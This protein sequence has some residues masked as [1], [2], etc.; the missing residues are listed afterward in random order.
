[1]K[2]LVIQSS[3][4]DPIGILGDHLVALGAELFTWLPEEQVAPPD[5]DFVGL[6]ILGGHMNA[7]EDDKFPHLKKLLTSCISFMQTTNPLWGFVWGLSS[8]PAP[9]GPRSIP[10]APPS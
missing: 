7:H 3:I 2:L 10:T 6:I 1:M 8:L 9:L 5:E 4:R